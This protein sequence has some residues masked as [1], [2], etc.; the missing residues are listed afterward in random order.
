MNTARIRLLSVGLV[1]G[2]ALG[3]LVSALV[4]WGGLR[5]VATE[6]LGAEPGDAGEILEPLVDGATGHSRFAELARRASPGV[7]NVHTSRTVVQRAPDFPFPELFRQFFGPPRG[8]S[9]APEPQQREFRVPSLGTGFVI[10]TDGLILTNHHVV[11]GVDEIEVRFLDGATAP[12]KLVGSDPLT[13]LALIQVEN[14]SDFTV[15]SLGDSDDILPGDYVVAIGN[16]FG[17]SHTVTLGIV[18][19][20]GRGLGGPYDDYIQTDA[21]INPGNS[22]GPLL[23]IRGA[24]VGINTAINPQANTIGFAVPINLAKGILPQLRE[25]GYVVRGW[26]G[27][28]IQPVTPKLQRAFGLSGREGAL[29]SEVTPGGPAEAAGVERGD[30]IVQYEGEPIREIRDLPR[31][32]TLTPV[33]KTVELEVVR[34]GERSK[35]QATIARLE[36]ETAAR[37]LERTPGLS[38]FGF[39]LDD[40]PAPRGR[41]GTA[42]AVIA[43]V[44]PGGPADAAGLLPGDVIVEIDRK[45]VGGPREVRELLRGQERALLLVEREGSTSFFVSLEREG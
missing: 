41:G 8:R 31:L 30:V 3:L 19:A 13:D 25:Q 1:T 45:S 34:E 29:V 18:S 12:G 35:L 4:P 40:R 44:E 33:G 17:L 22:G 16:P 32:V 37:T 5:A 24:V 21:A 15:L 7:V 20:K 14:R 2:V 28:S 9:P 27:V 43:R 6:P 26:L 36:D 42:G 23:D 38:G 11:E 10:S 39:E